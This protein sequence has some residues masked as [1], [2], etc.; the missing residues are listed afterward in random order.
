LN[1]NTRYW[2]RRSANVFSKTALTLSYHRVTET[3]VD[4]WELSVS[5]KNFEEQLQVL[6]K[7]RLLSFEKFALQQRAKNISPN[8]I[9]ITFDDGYGDNFLTAKPLLERYDCPATFFIATGYTNQQENFWWDELDAIFLLRQ[10]LPEQ[11]TVA[12][13]GKQF[14]FDFTEARELTPAQLQQHRNWIYP[15][16]P[17]TKRC[18]IYLAVWAMITPLSYE[19]KTNVMQLIKVW[20]GYQPN[21]LPENLPMNETQL[22]SLATHPLIKLGLHTVTHC[23]LSTAS[24]QQQYAEISDCQETLAKNYGVL[25]TTLAYPYGHYN[26]ETLAIADKLKLDAAVT[27]KG[28]AITKKTDPY[29]MGRFHVKNWSGEKFERVLAEWIKIY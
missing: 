13:R 19:E 15:K 18:Q 9:C 25:A 17:P 3:E 5:P 29:Q 26:A 24:A 20:A 1:L 16:E 14:Q 6:Q 4:P 10:R 12:V 22:Q 8:S 27:M 28:K 23:D 21:H 7:F 2:I 11:L